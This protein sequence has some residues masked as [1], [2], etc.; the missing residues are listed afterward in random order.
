MSKLT[1]RFLVLA[2]GA[3]ATATSQN[4]AAPCGEVAKMLSS[5]SA[6]QLEKYQLLRSVPL[7]SKDSAERYFNVDLDGDDISDELGAGCSSSNPPADPCRLWAKLSGGQQVHFD[8]EFDESFMVFRFRARIY[9]MTEK[10][11]PRAGK[12]R[13]SVYLLDGAGMNKVCSN[14]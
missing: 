13:R 6:E 9:V 14:I 7:G 2:L 4:A 12:G 1:F 11:G 5:R 3:C 10:F 8:F